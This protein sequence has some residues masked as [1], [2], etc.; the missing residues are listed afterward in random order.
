MPASEEIFD[1]EVENVVKKPKRKLTEKQLENLRIGREKMKL[2]RE[3]QKKNKELIAAG[4]QPLPVEPTKKEL[5]KDKAANKEHMKT[6]KEGH[7]Q[8]RKTLKQINAEKEA[9]ILEKLAKKEEE[10]SLKKSAR[11]ETFSN[12]KV[13]CLEKAKSVKEYKE[14]QAALDGIDEDTLHNDEKLMAY[15]KNVMAPYIK[16]KTKKNVK[17]EVVEETDEGKE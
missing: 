16:S 1:K 13:K 8:K 2:K 4:K 15:A 7:K 5:A 12:L 9:A 14:I 3:L 17:L 10:E 11:S 6:K